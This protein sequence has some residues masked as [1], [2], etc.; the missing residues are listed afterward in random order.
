MRTPTAAAIALTL[1]A[2]LTVG[3][4]TPA[5]A[6]TCTRPTSTVTIP[7]TTAKHST[8]IAHARRAVAHGYPTVMVWN[9]NGAAKRRAQLLKDVKTKRGHDRDEYP[10]ASGRAVVR[11]DVELVPSGQNRSAGAVMGNTMRRYCAGT[12]FRYAGV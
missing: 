1:A 4:A 2:G 9:P 5:Q 10:P 8:L 6:A 11:A 12:K 3:A 7:L